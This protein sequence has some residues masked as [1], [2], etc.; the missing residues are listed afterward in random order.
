MT[1]K[2]IIKDLLTDE[3]FI[4][5]MLAGDTKKH[6]HTAEYSEAVRLFGKI[7]LANDRIPAAD[8]AEIMNKILR[9]EAR[10]NHRLHIIRYA[11]VACVS[12]AIGLAAF[13]LYPDEKENEQ[14]EAQKNVITGENLAEKD[15]QFITDEEIV[16]FANDVRVN[17]SSNGALT[18]T[19]VKG[20]KQIKADKKTTNRIVVPYGKRSQLTLADGTEVWINA[21]ST[22]EF[23]SVFNG[24][25]RNI[26]VSGEIY[27]EVAP[28]LLHPFIVSTPTMDIT[29][30]GTAFN[31]T[32]YDGGAAA[33]VLVEGKVGV[34]TEISD[35]ETIL[36]P[37]DMLVINDNSLNINQVD[38]GKYISWKDGYIELN[39]TPV[40]DVLKQL[41][42]Y[43][44]LSFDID[45]NVEIKHITCTGKIV[46]SPN[47]DNL[48]NAI[49]IM[50]ST[51]YHREDNKI[52][53]EY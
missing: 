30:Y 14:P 28:D 38:V 48:M 49:S 15:I 44:N 8:Y 12:L 39:R 9:Q 53:I 29:A 4:A 20:E 42:L 7:R 19:D 46:L 17:V 21:G 10:R 24:A 22:L 31:V 33:V 27:I 47:L 34:K 45:E 51:K 35:V 26:T 43:Y 52:F 37:A 13:F 11:A 25:T 5:D 6:C 18:V 23:P 40:T 16:T 1:N 50:S 36:N 3:F 41:E 32:A 2:Q